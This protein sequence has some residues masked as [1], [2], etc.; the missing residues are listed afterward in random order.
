MRLTLRHRFAFA[1]PLPGGL[2]SPDAWDAL[3]RGDDSFGLPASRVEWEAAAARSGLEQRAVAVARVAEELGA[4]RVCSYGVGTGM[5]EWNLHRVAPQLELECTDFA[6]LAVARLAGHFDAVRLVE[7]DLRADPPR[8]AD[9]HLLNRVD[10]ELSDEEWPV[11][12]ARFQE[13]V[14]VVASELVGLRVVVR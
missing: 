10:T 13:P 14:L 1:R 6:P 4:R 11:V 9:L 7:H 3:R 8:D 5:F 12:F 2:D